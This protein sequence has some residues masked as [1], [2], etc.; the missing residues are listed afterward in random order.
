MILSD[1]RKRI[2]RPTGTGG[3]DGSDESIYDDAAIDVFANSSYRA[4]LDS[5]A[6]RE[7]EVVATLFTTAGVRNYTMPDPHDGLR[8][9]DIMHPTTLQHTPLD[10]MSVD[11]Y[12]Q[13][14][15]ES[16]TAWGYPERYVRESCLFRLW[17]TPNAI[18]KLHVRYW[19]IL[20]DLS[21]DTQTIEIPSVWEEPII[22]GA[23]H[24]IFMD[25]GNIPLAQAYVQYQK[26]LIENIVPI[27]TKE[28]EDYHR[29]GVEVLGREY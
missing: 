5:Y 6:F 22:M 16:E 23:V 12:K 13:R 3:P 29:A 20:V 28:E 14:W 9:I 8:G 2:R 1:M 27:Q 19:G 17:P 15:N 11:E 4:L 10:A 26:M 7:K 21:Q 18:Y 25:R 24:R